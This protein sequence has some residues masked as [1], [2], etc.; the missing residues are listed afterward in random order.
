MADLIHEWFTPKARGAVILA[1]PGA[2]KSYWIQKH[3]EAGWEDA[4]ML[5]EHDENFE[6]TASEEE[7]EAYYKNIDQRLQ[8][9][10]DKGV[11]VLS[12]LFWEF[13]P[14]AVVIPDEKVHKQYVKN[15]EDLNWDF[16]QEIRKILNDMDVPHFKKI[17]DAVNWIT[18]F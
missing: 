3:P 7:K 16:V 10:R 2:G 13:V 9:S 15:R 8:E 6:G 11:K 5:Y 18:K 4:D 12:S 1:P 17:D 14:D